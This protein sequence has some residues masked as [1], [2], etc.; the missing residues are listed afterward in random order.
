MLWPS[1]DPPLIFN[2]CSI[3]CLFNLTYKVRE[4]LAAE[5]GLSVRVVQVWFQNQRAKVKEHTHMRIQTHTHTHRA[6]CTNKETLLC[7]DRNQPAYLLIQETDDISL[8]DWSRLKLTFP[9][10]LGS[11]V[12]LLRWKTSFSSLLILNTLRHQ[13]GTGTEDCCDLCWCWC[14]FFFCRWRNWPG[15]SSSNRSS[16]SNSSS[17][18]LRNS[19]SFRHI[20]QVMRYSNAEVNTEKTWLK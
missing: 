11:C 18:R 2:S 16:S 4:T 8:W 20:I 5:T 13:G 3:S 19:I 7:L 6:L 9:H 10:S 1:H 17:S 14:W 15:G 12:S